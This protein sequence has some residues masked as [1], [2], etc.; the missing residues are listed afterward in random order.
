MPSQSAPQ[1][2]G[3]PRILYVVIAA[4]IAL[5]AIAGLDSGA[6]NDHQIIVRLASS[7]LTA[8]PLA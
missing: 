7:V 8:S 6:S 4:L 5:I 1:Q 2:S 3:P